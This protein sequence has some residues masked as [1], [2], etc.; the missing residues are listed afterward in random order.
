M[1][2]PR[3]SPPR[4]PLWNGTARFRGSVIL[5][6]RVWIEAAF[7]LSGRIVKV[8]TLATKSLFYDVLFDIKPRHLCLST[9]F[10]AVES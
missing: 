3:P 10:A 1:C 8:A 9:V 6:P 2:L 5:R 4:P 7:H